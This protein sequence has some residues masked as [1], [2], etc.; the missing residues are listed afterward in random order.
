[1]EDREVEET[2]V[3][4]VRYNA[5]LWTHVICSEVIG[6]RIDGSSVSLVIQPKEL[7]YVWHVCICMHV[8]MYVITV[9]TDSPNVQLHI[10]IIIVL[11]QGYSL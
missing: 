3:P 8:S 4:V 1:M 7:R 2:Y 11:V 10:C 5:C 6:L 9:D